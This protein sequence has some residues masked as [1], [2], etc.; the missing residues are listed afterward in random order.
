MRRLPSSWN[1]TMAKLGLLRRGA[2]TRLRHRI[3]SSV[4]LGCESLEDRR[5]LTNASGVFT[6]LDAT[7]TPGERDLYVN[8]TTSDRAVD[9]TGESTDHLTLEMADDLN[10]VRGTASNAAVPN[11]KASSVAQSLAQILTPITTNPSA[12]IVTSVPLMTQVAAQIGSASAT[13]PSLEA[14]EAE[15]QSGAGSQ[16]YAIG[17]FRYDDTVPELGQKKFYGA[18]YLVGL[19]VA[20]GDGVREI[21]IHQEVEV[22]RNG[23][24]I[25]YV[26]AYG[27]LGGPNVGTGF[28]SLTG[29]VMNEDG[30]FEE[31]NASG[32]GL[33][34]YINFLSDIAENDVITFNSRFDVNGNPAPGIGASMGMS[35]VQIGPGSQNTTANFAEA[36]NTYGFAFPESELA[37]NVGL[38]QL[39][40]SGSGSVAGDFNGD[41]SV[42][43][44][45]T[46]DQVD[47]LMNWAKGES[48]GN[49]VTK[50]FADDL[51][52]QS[53]GD[54]SIV[55]TE[56][57]ESTG[58]GLDDL[59][60]REALVGSGESIT[61]APWV[62]D[63]V[64]DEGNL[65]INRSVII[66]GPGADKL[67]IDADGGSRVF[68]V[69][70]AGTLDVTISGVTI[71]GGAVNGDGAGIWTY[72]ENLTLSNVVVTD[73]HATGT[74][75][76]GGGVWSGNGSVTVIDSTFHHNTATRGGAIR[77]QGFPS[78]ILN[79]SGSTFYQNE[80]SAGDGVLS[81]YYTT[82][83][84]ENTTISDN[85]AA[86]SAGAILIESAG[87]MEIV[88]STIVNNRAGYYGAGIYVHGSSTL[89]MHNSILAK[90]VSTNTTYHELY[91][92]I[93]ATSSYNIFG[94]GVNGATLTGSGNQVGSLTTEKD[95]L[96]APLGDYGGKTKTH[97]L[98]V[99]S[100][101]IDK[102]KGSLTNLYDQRGYAR[103]VEDP[104][105]TNGSDGYRD[106]GA[107]EAGEGTT[108]VV[109]SD[110]D[111]NDSIALK[112]TTDSLRLREALALS[113]ALAGTEVIRFDESLYAD[114]PAEIVLSYDGPDGGSV[115]D[116]L[117]VNSSVTIQG[118]GADKLSI[119]GN[120]VTRVML[121][122]A[123]DVV[124]EGVTI[125]GGSA[126]LGAGISSY[127][128]RLTIRNSRITNNSATSGGAGIYTGDPK[129]L[130]VINSEISNN[131]VTGLS[132]GGGA[133]IA[134][135]W[136]LDKSSIGVEI[137]NSTISGNIVAG[138][139]G[140]G[141]G[142]YVYLPSNSS[143]AEVKV[144][145][146]TIAFN[147]A[148]D[149]GG[150]YY[151]HDESDEVIYA[152]NSIIADNID[153]LDDPND[154]AGLDLNSASS[155]N[156][157]G[158]GGSG[159]LV[160]DTA[161]NIVLSGAETSGLMQLDF[162][163]GPTRTHA[164]R[165][166][167]RAIDAG[168]DAIAALFGLDADQRGFNRSEDSDYSLD[169]GIDIGALEL[170][171][172]EYYS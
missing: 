15:A 6:R 152:H 34:V 82:S 170:A 62:H 115:P 85:E 98:L 41:G 52:N 74:Q 132:G 36:I 113:A 122:S 9:D 117:M 114:D 96:L 86:Q 5:M 73:N 69:N 141:G 1:Q 10:A 99:G 67:A 55:T 124:I 142:L 145:N 78:A 50:S 14:Y 158:L 44:S 28:W 131:T 65:S 159:G 40:N 121:V 31:V 32:G 72:E 84:I 29:E 125:T 133:G 53:L 21:N 155:Y 156:L 81:T 24:T 104:L 118:P 76:L 20:N 97:A 48:E 64:L 8:T 140:Q 3:S 56:D 11:A 22:L 58:Y 7:P 144:I 77:T 128:N 4:K 168:D 91:G 83:Y 35:V 25:A 95:P 101:A 149:G 63:I 123:A 27:V 88:N 138:S 162:Y 143:G 2:S 19:G 103:E 107:Y 13:V 139:G 80:A 12:P 39:R 30:E 154:W 17:S 90:N 167:S 172:S 116:Q 109:R 151:Q 160:D 43:S 166:D 126:T 171:M 18:I 38:V 112:A 33:N 108:L 164:L 70:G 120:S 119:S 136:D 46:I 16:T 102:G 23:A 163:G 135:T 57:D 169:D 71:K 150:V 105:V 66:E 130:R 37:P 146:S 106:I 45:D 100:I 59:S 92:A 47:D 157:I 49:S 127:E 161:G 110:G 94:R 75:G 60:L 153:L 26:S 137:I 68:V 165:N 147:K 87:S 134:A 42:D 54:V 79:I 93:V 89:T 111:R 61:F 129:L 148:A 51:V